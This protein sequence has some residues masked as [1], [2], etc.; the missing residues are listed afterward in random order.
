MYFSFCIGSI[1]CQK[2]RSYSVL[3]PCGRAHRQAS[4]RSGVCGLV[5]RSEIWQSSA[6]LGFGPLGTPLRTLCQT[7]PAECSPSLNHC[8]ETRGCERWDSGKKE[9]L[10]VLRGKYPEGSALAKLVGVKASASPSY[11]GVV[12]SEHKT[13]L[14]EDDS[15]H[16]S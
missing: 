11:S 14:L 7:E 15:K 10:E 3:L 12:L 5:L 2:A 9:R 4:S 1:D 13:S 8:G 16:L 6:S